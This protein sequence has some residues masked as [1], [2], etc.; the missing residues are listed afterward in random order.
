MHYIVMLTLNQDLLSEG[1][2]TEDFYF[3]LD[4]WS[5]IIWIGPQSKKVYSN[6]EQQTYFF[7]IFRYISVVYESKKSILLKYMKCEYCSIILL[8]GNMEVED[9]ITII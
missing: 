1:S 2:K 4:T 5:V 8:H 9:C 6:L 7:D 3:Q